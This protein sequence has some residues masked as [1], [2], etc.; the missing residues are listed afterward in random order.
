MAGHDEQATT[1]SAAEAAVYD[2]Q[3]R[4]WGVE[5]QKRLQKARVLVSG[6]SALGS[7]L[8]KNLTLA[9]MGVTLHDASSVSASDADSQFLLSAQDVGLNRAE[10]ALTRVRE[11][12]PL[13]Q[14][15]AET[16]PLSDLPD[17]FFQG[18]SVVC[19]VGA[20][21][22]TELRL[23]VLCRSFGSAFFAARSFGFDGLV[24]ADLGAAHA[25]RRNAVGDAPPGEPETTAFPPL[26]QAQKV[27]WST[28]QSARKRA[29]QLPKVFVK[30]QRAW[31]TGG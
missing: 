31:R 10:A 6:L 19:T 28:L 12:N 17:D 5:A 11:L 29:P 16:R 8:A 22:K 2:R 25:F 24:F 14:V 7:E 13:V 30:N 9:G 15:Q 4:L 1:F 20:D 3:M 18:F 21:L 23:D 26:E 27:Q